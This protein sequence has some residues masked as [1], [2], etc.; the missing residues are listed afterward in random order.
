[1]LKCKINAT[2]CNGVENL[3][4]TFKFISQ[5]LLQ[6]FKMDR[7]TETYNPAKQLFFDPRMTESEN[8]Y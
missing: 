5:I 3:D 7:F 2:N 6:L 1:M 4:Q 8:L